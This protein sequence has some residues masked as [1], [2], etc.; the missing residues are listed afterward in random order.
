MDKEQFSK[1]YPNGLNNTIWLFHKA[2]QDIVS[3]DEI[4]K[5]IKQ[6]KGLERRRIKAFKKAYL[7]SSCE[8]LPIWPV[9]SALDSATL[10][11]D[12]IVF[13]VKNDTNIYRG[14]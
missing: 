5:V 4:D 9:L 3:T 8:I 10:L 12:I 1:T 14:E 11:K 7:A 13:M 2:L 6:A